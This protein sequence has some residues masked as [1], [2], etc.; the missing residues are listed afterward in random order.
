MLKKHFVNFIIIVSACSLFP[1]FCMAAV[2][3]NTVE[4]ARI[5]GMWFGTHQ[6]DEIDGDIQTLS[7]FNS[8]GTFVIEFRV[9]QDG[10]LVGE[11]VESGTWKLKDGVKTLVT[12]H[13]NGYPLSKEEI[14][15]DAYYIHKLTNTEQHYEHIKT[16]AKFNAVR[17]DEGFVFP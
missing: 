2:S 16:G 13:I 7:R 6:Q 4:S 5:V 3:S 14:I 12:T 9:I 17:V 10:K 15:T 11:Q 8:D 1:V